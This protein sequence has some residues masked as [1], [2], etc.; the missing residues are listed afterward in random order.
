MLGEASQQI[1]QIHVDG[2]LDDPN[3]TG[4][5]LPVVSQALQQLQAELR[6]MNDRATQPPQNSRLPK[7]P[8]QRR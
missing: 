7:T 4:E 3:T 6:G 1:M 8:L 5:A 2:T